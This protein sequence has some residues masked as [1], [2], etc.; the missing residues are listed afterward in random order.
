[1]FRFSAN[2]LVALV[3]CAFGVAPAFSQPALDEVG[4]LEVMS[5]VFEHEHWTVMTDADGN[6]MAYQLVPVTNGSPDPEL[7]PALAEQLAQYQVQ[8]MVVYTTTMTHDSY[9]PVATQIQMRLMIFP[10]ETAAAMWLAETYDNTAST[11]AAAAA[12]GQFDSQIAP[13]DPLP[14]VEYPL[15]GWTQVT[16]FVA[17]ST[18]D[19]SGLAS[20]VRY[21][22]QIGRTVVSAQVTGPFVDFNFDLAIGLIDAQAHCLNESPFCEGVTIMEPLVGS[23]ETLNGKLTYVPE[24]VEARWMWPVTAPVRAPEVSTSFAPHG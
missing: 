19:F 22:A 6:P 17:N 1:M 10:D 5:R 12:A 2:L 21:Q 9:E 18:E 11:S 7:N 20:T 4:P 14:E 24:G 13:I 8:E 15:I 16:D 23:W 3:V